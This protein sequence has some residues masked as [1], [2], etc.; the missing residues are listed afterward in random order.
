MEVRRRPERPCW[1]PWRSPPSASSATR[2]GRT[3]SG[4]AGAPRPRCG[5]RPR[6]PV[7]EHPGRRTVASRWTCGSSGAPTARPRCSRIRRTTCFPYAPTFSRWIEL[8]G[9]GD[10]I[11]RRR[12]RT[13]PR[14][15]RRMLESEHVGDA[16][17]RAGLR[18]RRR[19]GGSWGSTTGVTRREWSAVET[20]ALRAAAGALGA[21]I[22]REAAE[23]EGRAAEQRFRT[24]IEQLPAISYMDAVQD[25]AAHHLHQPA[26]GGGSSATRRRSGWPTRACGPAS[27]IP[28]TGPVRWPRTLR[29][30]ETGEPFALEYRVFAKDGTGRV[31][32]RRGRR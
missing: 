28:T 2:S 3:G 23:R 17:H 27:F 19:G 9:R 24:M 12:Q 32:A 29:H 21:A 26:G 14:V 1:E 15:E 8:L 20:D 5:R 31:A 4:G 6:V 16:V 13:S 10:V 25:D 30:N 18:G 11:V 7:P 22:E